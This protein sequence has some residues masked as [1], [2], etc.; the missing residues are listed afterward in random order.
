V[1]VLS[2]RLAR[3]EQLAGAQADML[4]K[5]TAMLQALLVR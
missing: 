1:D 4:S 2:A 5:Q 3:L